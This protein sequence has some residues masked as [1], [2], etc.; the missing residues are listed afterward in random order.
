MALSSSSPATLSFRIWFKS[1]VV[2]GTSGAVANECSVDV[3]SAAPDCRA[4]AESRAETT[5]WSSR[6]MCWR[7]RSS[8]RSWAL[9]CAS[10]RC[11]AASWSASARADSLRVKRLALRRFPAHS[12]GVSNVTTA[13]TAAVMAVAALLDTRKAAKT[14]E[15]V[16]TQE[17]RAATWDARGVAKS[18]S[19]KKNSNAS[20]KAPALPAS[21]SPTT[22]TPHIH[23]MEPGDARRSSTPTQP[24]KANA[25]QAEAKACTRN[26]PAPARSTASSSQITAK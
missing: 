5:S 10:S 8:A 22:A 6:A 26:P 14:S 7:S 4:M 25:A 13:M 15:T 24:S 23:P 17:A 16:K 19:E 11:S 1:A 21:A 2:A 18:T 9:R 12:T 3:C 20:T